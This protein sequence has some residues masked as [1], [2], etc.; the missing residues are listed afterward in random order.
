MKKVERREEK[1]RIKREQIIKS[2]R[3]KKRNKERGEY[4]GG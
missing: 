1:K 4:K 3:I 2:I